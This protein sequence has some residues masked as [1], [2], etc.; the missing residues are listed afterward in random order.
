M[1]GAFATEAGAFTGAL[2]TAF[3]TGFEAVFAT[4]F[5][6]FLAAGLTAGFEAGLA[7]G[8]AATFDSGL[9]AALMA[10]LAAFDV[11]AVFTGF[12]AA[13]SGRSGV[14]GE[15][16]TRPTD[17]L[18]VGW[19]LAVPKPNFLRKTPNIFDSI[20]LRCSIAAPGQRPGAVCD[21]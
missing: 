13:A 21:C 5:A 17:W 7:A 9:G 16:G 4:A 19:D 12:F 14:N 10:G 1:P 2:T 11:T 3:G 18:T 6:G 8:L 20:S 15:A